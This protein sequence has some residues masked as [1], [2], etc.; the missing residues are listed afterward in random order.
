MKLLQRHQLPLFVGV[1]L[2]LLALWAG[3][4]PLLGSGSSV[5]GGHE[6]RWYLHWSADS[7]IIGCHINVACGD[8]CVGT[9]WDECEA[10]TYYNEN[11]RVPCYGGAMVIAEGQEAGGGQAWASAYPVGCWGEDDVCADIHHVSYCDY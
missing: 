5:L 8:H 6:S 9:K 11:H 4:G 2:G 1:V 10:A 7:Q 3:A